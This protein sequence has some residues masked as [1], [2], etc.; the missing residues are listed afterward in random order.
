MKSKY[1]SKYK[2][3]KQFAKEFKQSIIQMNLMRLGILPEKSWEDLKK[4]LH[5]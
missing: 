5:E 1:K 4:E 3:K 2:N